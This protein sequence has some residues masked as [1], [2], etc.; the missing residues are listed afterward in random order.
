MPIL[1][2]AAIARG[3]WADEPQQVAYLRRLKGYMNGDPLPNLDPQA[4]PPRSTM[5]PT[6]SDLT[7]FDAV[8]RDGVYDAL[9]VDIETVGNHITLVG[10]TG[11]SLQREEVGPNLSLPFRLRGG[12][13]YWY[14]W[15]DHVAATA[16]LYSWL[17]DE[18][19]AKVFHNGLGF[20]VP[21]LEENG[22]VVRGALHDTMIMAHYTYPEMRKGL[23]YLATLYLGAPV[24][25]TL[26]DVDDEEEG[27]A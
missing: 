21:L 18:S 16:W 4:A 15:A 5:W 22:F 8:L 6:L 3:R 17:A 2:P 27:K 25:K 24:W 19:L 7:D 14:K 20:D 12:A 9:A 10:L 11:M 1:H 23:Q 26:V 13:F